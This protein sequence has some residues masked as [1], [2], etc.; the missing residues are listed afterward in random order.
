[1]SLN[2]EPHIFNIQHYSLHDGPGIRTIVFLKGCPMRCRWCCNP[3]SQNYAPEISYL[4]NRCI[5]KEECGFC[6]NACPRR[7]ITFEENGKPL[8]DREKCAGCI[9]DAACTEE[10]KASAQFIPCAQACPA[11][12]M[13][14]EGRIYSVKELVDIVERDS[15]FYGHGQGGLT[16]SGGEPLTHPRFLAEL[17]K[18][19]KKRRIHTAIETCGYAAY[20]S[21]AA[22]APY[23][24]MIHYDIKSMDCGKHREYTGCSN[25]RILENF[26]RLCRDFPQI[27]K[28]VRTPVIPGFN[29]TARDIREIRDFV[30]DK[31]GVTYE[32]LPYHSFGKGK[33]KTL[34]RP[35]GM[36]DARLAPG[37]MDKLQK[38]A[39]EK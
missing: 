9:K 25:E 26:R 33:Y 1:M 17:L 38:I 5:G 16:V 8:I 3:E 22:A 2:R 19:A 21:L 12:A 34:G 28:K 24:D 39:Q 27:P 20:E 11:R 6:E 29:D 23:L 37:V 32:L 13:K 30:K 4:E 31:P 10:K 14:Q 15:V 7:A 36:G 18:E 35:Y